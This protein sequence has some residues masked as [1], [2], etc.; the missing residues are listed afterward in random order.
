[1]QIEN[2]KI[3][4]FKGIEEADIDLQGKNVYLIGGNGTG[5]TSFIDAVWCGLTGKNLPTEP[6]TKG[7]KKGE[8]RIDLG[9]FV[10]VTKFTKGKPAQFVLENKEF[11]KET[12]KFIA[13]P[14][15]YLNSRVGILDFD[16]NEFFGKSDAEQVK[17]FCKVSGIDFSDIDTDLE[18]LYESRK[19]DKKK[20]GEVKAK[21]NYYKK[22][23]AEKDLIDVIEMSKRIAVE[24]T[25]IETFSKVESG[26]KTRQDRITE[27]DAQI[28]ALL[29]ERNGT[30]EGDTVVVKG[31]VHQIKDGE[32][33]L[34]VVE[35]IPLTP[36]ELLK[37]ET[38]FENSE[39]LNT[40]IKEAK[41]AKAI[42]EEVKKLEDIIEQADKDIDKKKIEKTKRIS[43]NITVEGLEYSTE[44]ECFLWNGLPFERSQINTA[45]QLIAGVKIGSIML[46]ELK[47]LKIDASLIDKREFDKVLQWSEENKIELFIELVDREAEALQIVID[48]E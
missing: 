17:Y 34:K 39:N 40:T 20:L 48:E 13:S 23:D 15:A 31:L 41:D 8:I 18:E 35:N 6:V 2:I 45:S 44:N 30:V 43:K 3:R 4:N 25:K 1:M 12:E 19:F 11:T 28:D 32:D 7:N 9:E 22:E 27:I 5:K 29:L 47:I 38:D 14:R 21:V 37:L 46:K 16:I 36:E 24:K 10:A 42:D 33:W 26:I